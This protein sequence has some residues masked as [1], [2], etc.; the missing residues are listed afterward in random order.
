MKLMK[1]TSEGFT[2]IEL[3]VVIAIIAILAGLLLPALAN[4]KKKAQRI[5]CVS[6]LK[7]IGLAAKTWCMENN[8]RFPWHLSVADGGTKTVSDAYRHWQVMSNELSN[9]KIL[10]C[11]SD[12]G[13]TPADSFAGTAATSLPVLRANALSYGLGMEAVETGPS[14]WLGLDR[15]VTGGSGTGGACGAAGM[16]P[17]RITAA[18]R[19]TDQLHSMAGDI[20]LTDGSAHQYNQTKFTA[21]LNTLTIGTSDGNFSNCAMLPTG[22]VP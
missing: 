8:N 22:N 4:A 18:G 10:I 1:K 14:M 17:Y 11:P 21:I 16:V 7:Q 5:K 19:W 9:G 15:N 13:K 12:T 20:L 2:L 6:N 3:L